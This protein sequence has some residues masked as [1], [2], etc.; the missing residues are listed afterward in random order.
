MAQRLA[1]AGPL[2]VLRAVKS[3]LGRAIARLLPARAADPRDTGEAHQWMYDRVSLERLLSQNG[4]SD[5]RVCRYD[6][7]R[8]PGWDRFQ[9]DRSQAGDRP[10]KPDSLFAEAV[11]P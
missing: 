2:G 3:R 5:F 1:T 9:L 10:R 8:I 7:S 11:K 4:F 6:E